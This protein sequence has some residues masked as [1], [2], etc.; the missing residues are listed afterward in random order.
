MFAYCNKSTQ[1]QRPRNKE[2]K[3]I[4]FRSSQGKSEGYLCF[5]MST[6]ALSCTPQSHFQVSFLFSFSIIFLW[7]LLLHCALLLQIFLFP[8]QFPSFT[9]GFTFHTPVSLFSLQSLL[10]TL[11]SPSFTKSIT[12]STDFVI[13]HW[14]HYLFSTT[15]LFSFLLLNSH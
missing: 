4:V 12:F 13:F 8:L 2:G 7:L 11:Q 1:H 15:V 10:F 5:P 14:R 6:M 9:A 3:D